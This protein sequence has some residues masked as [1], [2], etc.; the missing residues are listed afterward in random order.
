[1]ERWRGGEVYEV[2]EVCEV[3]E[4]VRREEEEEGIGRDRVRREGRKGRVE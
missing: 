4:G 3:C 1:M 2:C